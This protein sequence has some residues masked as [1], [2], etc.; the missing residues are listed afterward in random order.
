MSATPTPSSSSS[1]S[2]SSSAPASDAGSLRIDPER[3]RAYLDAFASPDV[4]GTPQGGVSRPAASDAD[5]AARDRFTETARELGLEVRF[6]DVG[7]M[8]ARRRG[9]DDAALPVLIGSH[10]DTVVPGGRFD[11]I[12]GVAI[13]LETVA[14]M[15]DADARTQ[16]PVVVVNWMGE[17]GARFPPAMLGTGVITGQWDAAYAHSRTDADGIRLDDALERIGYLGE[18][19]HRVGDFFASLEAHIEQGP[20][21]EQS[22][23]LVGIVPR[24]EPVRWNMVRVTGT[25]GHAGGPGPGG[26]H[27]AVVAA[28]RMIVAARDSAVAD[29]AFKTTVGRMR[30]EPGSTN[31][32]AHEAEFSLDVRAHDDETL[33]RRLD[34]LEALFRSIAGEEGVGVEIDRF[35]SMRSPAFDERIQRM[36]ERAA[37]ARGIR[38]QHTVGTIGH[39]SVHLAGAGPTAMLFTQT[40]DGRSHCEDE[41]APWE[42][43][44]ATAQV[45]ADTALALA[46]SRE[47]DSAS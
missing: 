34:E 47:L 36:L 20:Q 41:F 29:G 8:T 1:S 12:L 3:L 35:W 18:P 30:V 6:D 17:E 42:S 46:N 27:E 5:K 33:D 26:R 7:N 19:E 40:R 43:V 15:N 23:A 14:A 25:G 13:A 21:L 31:V 4:G 9:A 16:R 38:W 11:G 39:D 44:V 10:L 24:V 22:G 28:A 32:I 45:F 2:S 37:D